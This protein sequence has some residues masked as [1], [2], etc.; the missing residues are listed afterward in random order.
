MK[1]MLGQVLDF[2]IK[3]IIC[4]LTHLTSEYGN[5]THDI[6]ITRQQQQKGNKT[7]MKKK[8]RKNE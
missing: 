3:G 5:N 7:I 4:R 2:Q 8:K 1:N 6:Y